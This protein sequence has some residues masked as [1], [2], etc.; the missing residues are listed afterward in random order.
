M[1]FSLVFIKEC[2]VQLSLA[3]GDWLDMS[4]LAVIHQESANIVTLLIL[5]SIASHI[6]SHSLCS[7]SLYAGGLVWE[8]SEQQTSA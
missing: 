8:V 1:M 7:L 3:V 6:C 2:N 4:S 5:S